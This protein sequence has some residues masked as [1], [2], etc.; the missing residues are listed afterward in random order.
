MTFKA[1]FK[2]Y[3]IV[4]LFAAVLGI[5]SL[6]DILKPDSDFSPSE[7]RELKQF[8]AF[9]YRRL[10]EGDFGLDFEDYVNDQFILRNLWIN[11]KSVSEY[12]TG[13]LE[14]NGV[15]YGKNGYM[16]EKV[17]SADQNRIKKNVGYIKEF[18][19][20]CG[21]DISFLLVP[22]SYNVL[23]E[24][25]PKYADN[26]DQNP[27]IDDIFSQLSECGIK[28]VDVRDVLSENA[29]KYIFYRTD[30]HW[31]NLGAQIAFARFMDSFSE[32]M[33]DLSCYEIKNYGGFLGTY[34]NKCKLFSAVPDTISYYDFPVASVTYDGETSSSLHNVDKFSD[35]D[36]YAGF[37]HG[38]NG[39]TVISSD[40]PGASGSCLLIKD[41]YGN[42]FAPFLLTKYKTVVAVDLRYI[43]QNLSEFMAANSFDKIIV[44]YSF[45][46]FSTDINIAKITL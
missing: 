17:T 10:V 30:H 44:L 8:P 28:T 20:D 42:S 11:V 37:I 41:S 25:M 43:P 3:F 2:K 32:P 26:I 38:N 19:S 1:A 4:V 46:N 35:Y 33:P 5:L 22:S 18:A 31:T 15:I 34:Y 21:F 24:Y 40:C 6:A 12:V 45:S 14:N 29:D 16:F 9:S 7:N 27:I 36:A 13:K 39:I 23:S